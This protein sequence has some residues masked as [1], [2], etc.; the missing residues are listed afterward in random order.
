MG[1][2][3]ILPISKKRL[4]EKMEPGIL[5]KYIAEEQEMTVINKEEMF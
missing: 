1:P 2:N 4:S 3:S 5:L